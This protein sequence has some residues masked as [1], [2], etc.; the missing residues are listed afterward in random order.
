M[1]ELEDHWKVLKREFLSL[2]D[3]NKAFVGFIGSLRYYRWIWSP[4][5]HACWYEGK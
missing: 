4:S 5:K 1:W 2:E 3:E